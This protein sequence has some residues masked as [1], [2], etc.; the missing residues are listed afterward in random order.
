[1]KHQAD[2]TNPLFCIRCRE[3]IEGRET[4]GCEASGDVDLL[5]SNPG[6]RA[7][8]VEAR[9]SL[10]SVQIGMMLDGAGSIDAVLARAEDLALEPGYVERAILNA[11][12]NRIRQKREGN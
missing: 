2:P 8:S 11:V 12:E 4:E 9:K 6:D 5:L 3:A 7:L 1:M 10:L